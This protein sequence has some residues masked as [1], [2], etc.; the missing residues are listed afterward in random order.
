MSRNNPDRYIKGYSLREFLLP[1]LGG[2]KAFIKSKVWPSEILRPMETHNCYT[3]FVFIRALLGLAENNEYRDDVRNGGTKTIIDRKTGQP[4]KQLEGEKV[5]IVHFN[6]IRVGTDNKV[7]I[8]LESIRKKMGIQRFHSPIL[9]KITENRIFFILDDS[10][11]QMLGQTFVM[12][13]QKVM[14]SILALPAETAKE[15]LEELPFISTPDNFDAEKFISGFVTYFNSE[16][17]KK[18]LRTFPTRGDGP[19]PRAGYEF[20][21]ATVLV[22]EKGEHL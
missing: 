5:R 2:D 15:K 21:E 6:G 22:L 1:S 9:I 4:K 10:W 3:S 19:R 16:E 13:K 11:K 17:V 12:A 8:P 14:E 18:R 7:K 20:R